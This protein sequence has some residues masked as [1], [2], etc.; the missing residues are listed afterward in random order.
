MRWSMTLSGDFLGERK[1]LF[2]APCIMWN[3]LVHWAWCGLNQCVSFRIWVTKKNGRINPSLLCEL[4]LSSSHYTSPAENHFMLQQFVPLLK[5]PR[6]V[7]VTLPQG[8]P[9]KTRRPFNVSPTCSILSTL[10]KA[11]CEP[12]WTDNETKLLGLV[13][14]KN[15]HLLNMYV[16]RNGSFLSW[17]LCQTLSW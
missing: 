10:R 1:V 13:G 8:S 7:T 12:T 16:G 14:V 4:P 6:S 11:G 17:L 2:I 15:K 3:T 9:L 5:W